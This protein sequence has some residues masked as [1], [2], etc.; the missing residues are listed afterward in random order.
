MQRY[1]V[2]LVLWARSKIYVHTVCLDFGPDANCIC[3]VSGPDEKGICLVSGPIANC[4]MS[5]FWTCCKLYYV[6]FLGQMQTVYVWYLGQMHKVYVWFPDLLQTVYVW[7]LGL[8]QT[9]L[10]Y[11]WFLGLLQTVY[12]WFLGQMPTRMSGMRLQPQ[13]QQQQR[14]VNYSTWIFL[15]EVILPTLQIPILTFIFMAVQFIFISVNVKESHLIYSM[16]IFLYI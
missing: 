10:L 14:A 9:V 16:S 6:W 5:G 12:C 15:P 4:I 1:I 11:V 7:F 8:L 3:L 2:Y 13:K